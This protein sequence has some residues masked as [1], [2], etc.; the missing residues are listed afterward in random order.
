MASQLYTDLS[1]EHYIP[2]S[3]APGYS[4]LDTRY[5]SKPLYTRNSRSCGFPA[6]NLFISQNY[7]I[8][9]DS[10]LLCSPGTTS[11]LSHNHYPRLLFPVISGLSPDLSH[12]NYPRLPALVAF[13]LLWPPVSTPDLSH[14]PPSPCGLLS[15]HL[16]YFTS[17]TQDSQIL[18]LPS[19]SPDLFYNHRSRLPAPVVS[20]LYT[21]PISKPLYTQNSQLLWPPDIRSDL[22]HNHYPRRPALVASR[23][24]I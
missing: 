22:S 13:Q 23:L 14:I 16:I 5:I 20:W 7:F 17:T 10:Q 2:K 24:Y 21:C 6:L 1:H 4:R 9:K 3:Q 11:D 19:S 15:L 12:N 8:P 18:W